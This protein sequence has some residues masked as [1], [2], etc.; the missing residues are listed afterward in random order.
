MS[1]IS[2]EENII[3]NSVSDGITVNSQEVLLYVNETFAKMVGYTVSE[4]IGMNVLEVTAPEHLELVKE[5]TRKRQE[6]L[7]VVPIYTL[8]LVRKDG[9]CFPV[10]FSVSRI[11]FDGKSSSLTIIRDI[12]ERV[13]TQLDYISVFETLSEAICMFDSEKF[14][15]ANEAYLKFRGYKALDEF[16]GKSITGRIHPEERQEAVRVIKDRT[17]KG[18]SSSGVWRIENDD[19]SYQAMNIRTSLLPG[20]DDPIFIAILSSADIDKEDVVSRVTKGDLINEVN[21]ALTVILGY[22]EIL[23]EDENT[24][25]TPEFASFFVAI[26]RNYARLKKIIDKI[27]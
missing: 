22:V 9:S 7:D 16:V 25:M 21:S 8:E 5:R 19:G 12:S 4:L 27:E 11:D 2:S 1:G 18:R 24:V 26:E 20:F 17:M 13:K 15:W 3:L 6:G 14:I 23:K 10:E